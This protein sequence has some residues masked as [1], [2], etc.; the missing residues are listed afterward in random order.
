MKTTQLPIV[1]LAFANDLDNHLNTL[2]DES[3]DIFRSLQGLEK[4]NVIAIH[5]E[6]SAQVD[7]LYNDL[8]AY[9]DQI[10][11][12]HYAGHADGSMLQLE[13]GLASA[14]GIAGLLAQQASLKLVFLNGCATKDQVKLL[15]QA[16]VPA[17][18]ATAVK[19]NDSKATSLST[20]FYAALASGQSIYE[21][22]DSAHNYIEA[23]F[24]NKDEHQLK[25]TRQPNFSF[26]EQETAAEVQNYEF[27]WTLYTRPDA[28]ADLK[29]WRLP[30]A[31]EGWQI[32]LADS[33]GSIKNLDGQALSIDYRS[34]TRT[35]DVLAC[36]GCGI[37]SLKLD[38]DKNQCPICTNNNTETVSA[39]TAIPDLVLPYVISETDAHVIA[40]TAL[41]IKPAES[42]QVQ[43]IQLPY[44]VFAVDTRTFITAERG[45]VQDIY[46]DT[47][48]LEWTDVK[49][50]IELAVDNFLVPAFLGVKQA[51]ANS[52]GWQWQFDAAKPMQQLDMS[53]RFAALEISLETAFSQVD[54]CLQQEILEQ[55]PERLGG[56]EQ[57]NI[58]TDT[59]YKSISAH[60]VLL[61]YWC[62]TVGEGDGQTSVLINAQTG[63]VKIPE[64]PSG[65]VL[66][67]ES[68]LAMQQKST[69]TSGQAAKTSMLVSIYSGMGIGAMIGL[70]MGLAAPQSADAKSIVAIFIGAVGVGLAALLGLNDRNFSTA[71]G[72]RIG[73]FGLA[74]AVSALTGIYVRDNNLLSPGIVMQ[75]KEL[76]EVFKTLD[77]ER[78]LALLSSTKI[79]S[80]S[81][82]DG[83]KTQVIEQQ[84]NKPMS[85]LFSSPVSL[86][87]CVNLEPPENENNL[88]AEDIINNIKLNGGESWEQF[89]ALVQQEIPTTQD[90]KAVLVL[91]RNAVCKFAPF[92]QWTKPKPAQ[93]QQLSVISN[94]QVT[95]EQIVA[96]YSTDSLTTIKNQLSA[97]LAPKQQ[98]PALKLMGGML[99]SGK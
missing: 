43:Q 60:T 59:R 98:I 28:E 32:Q 80:T 11:I 56:I 21:A 29:Q 82:E 81:N 18:I 4:D 33:Q 53:T 72:L 55:I 68:N 40:V 93:C 49:A 70:L 95:T 42:I 89:V 54:E 23:K 64:N 24:I 96:A 38:K 67:N 88:Q 58:A 44:W 45:E 52:H 6:E 39:Q 57:R 69:H 84:L 83:S 79:S 27:E 30:N 31:R 50:E 2:K 25:F 8:L 14:G 7:E 78:L 26:A 16:G 35:I 37:R 12:F 85:A 90:Q 48:K 47:L 75:A 13:G 97:S 91:A 63:A 5:R 1:F 76:R 20:A 19:I 74:V 10:V 73:S 36:K 65:P 41:G 86:E 71:K 87:K 22:F 61:P 3:R 94:S 9:D 51:S 17:V 46:A 34:R 15:H 92:E 66:T 99:C 77:D 62:A